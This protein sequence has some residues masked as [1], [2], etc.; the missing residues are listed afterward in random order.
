MAASPPDEGLT[1]AD[2]AV[3]SSQS[4]YSEPSGPSERSESSESG[5]PS[6]PSG[7]SG[8]S[9]SSEPTD[10]S[11]PSDSS[12]TSEPS[13]PKSNPFRDLLMSEDDCQRAS[14]VEISQRQALED[15]RI[16]ERVVRG[17]YAGFHVL[18][19]E[20]IVWDEVFGSMESAIESLGEPI[21]VDAFQFSLIENLAHIQDR[22]FALWRINEDGSRRFARVGMVQSAYLGNVRLAR[23]E[24]SLRIVEAPDETFVTHELV[25]CP[26]LDLEHTVRRIVDD[27]TEQFQWG[28]LVLSPEAQPGVE[29]KTLAPSGEQGSMT[30]SFSPLDFDR[31]PPSRGSRLLFELFS[32]E[33]TPRLQINS[34]RTG[35]PEATEAFL[36]TAEKLREERVILV[37][38]RG[39]QGGSDG[40][41]RDWFRRLTS[42]TF[43]YHD[44]EELKSDVTLQGDLNVYTCMHAREQRMRGPEG[45]AR[46]EEAMNRA[47]ARLTDAENRHGSSFQNISRRQAAPIHGTAAERFHGTLLLLVDGRCASAC[48]NFIMYA[49]Q[50]PSTVVIGE[51]TAGVWRIA[52]MRPYRL[53]NSGIW[54]TVGYK[55]F[56]D[57]GHSPENIEGRGHLPDIWLHTSNSLDIASRIGS[58][59]Q[60]PACEASTC[61]NGGAKP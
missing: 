42:D 22:H 17:G 21:A 28:L 13:T 47:L 19:K 49:R 24:D 7:P 34:F 4:Q 48:E 52:E 46:T 57:A 61:L 3:S 39:N 35:D 5:D 44:M 6:E 25:K 41:A 12:E 55:V 11:E 32:D 14:E 1:P 33:D 54:V 59:L 58:C 60:E 27:G 8:C 26:G 40:V 30:V 31:Q 29:C 10:P 51:N 56:H 38:L 15:L 18:A 16:L 9:E 50:L 37:D 23:E 45:S 36:E 43:G 2:Q 53:P 20:G